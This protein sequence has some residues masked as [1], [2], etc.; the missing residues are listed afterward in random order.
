MHLLL[1]R[2]EVQASHLEAIAR[3]L[4]DFHQAADIVQEAPDWQRLFEDFEDL[5]Q[6]VPQLQDWYGPETAEST[7]ELIAG[8][9]GFLEQMAPTIQRRFEAGFWRDGH[10]DLHTGNI[11]L[12]E[13]PVIFDGIE[14]NDHFRQLD[15]LD[16]IA[17]LCM[18][19]DFFGRED[20]SRVLIEHY[21]DFFPFEPQPEDRQLFLYYLCYR[22]N[23]RLKVTA[24]KSGTQAPSEQDRQ[25]MQRYIDLL[26]QYSNAYLKGDS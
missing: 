12:L 2:G 9:R 7:R 4:A 26:L 20:L 14:F 6:V 24:L 8:T 23:V 25:D 17:F 19:L 5:Q 10:G 1:D 22:A 18:D 16:E 15:I 13:Q 11:F 21:L 3:K